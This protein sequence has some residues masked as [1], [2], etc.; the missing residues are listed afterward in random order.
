MKRIVFIVAGVGVGVICLLVG[1][2]AYFLFF[3]TPNTDGGMFTNFNFGDTEDPSVV[4]PPE[5][6]PEVPVVDVTS[7]ERLRQLTTQPVAGFNEIQLTPSSTPQARYI[8]AGTGHIFAIDLETGEE[9]RVSATTIPLTSAGVLT[10]NGQYVLIQSGS[11]RGAEHIVGIL[12]TTS[13][14]L[15]NFSISETVTSFTATNENT[16][17]YTTPSAN[18]LIGRVYD[19]AAN[20][21][22]SLFT[23]PFNDATI[24]WG[25]TEAGPHHVYPHTSSQLEGYAYAF[26]NEG[27]D[28]L[29][30]SGYGLSAIG[31]SDALIYSKQVNGEYQTFMISYGQTSESPLVVVPEKCVF[32]PTNSQT[33]VCGVDLTEYSHLMPDPWY[34]GNLQLS[35]SLWEFDTE[36]ESAILLAS[37]ESATG[38]EVDLINPTFSANGHNL[39]FQNKTDQT[40]W[41]YGYRLDN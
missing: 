17:L 14:E 22:E 29:P 3:A 26:T 2:W 19:P 33:S 37:P 12:S 25:D 7:P 24:R 30:A 40:L 32:S 21:I 31:S 8:E 36:S 1:V 15:R 39:Y 9:T 38:R 13:D 18:G 27:G 34:K 35:D 28:R 10:P 41:L 4:L 5:P 20:T 11:G 16:F 23:I 6:E